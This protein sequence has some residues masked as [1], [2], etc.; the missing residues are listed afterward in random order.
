MRGVDGSEEESAD[1]K[2][3]FLPHR[4]ENETKVSTMLKCPLQLDYMLLIIRIRLPQFVKNLHFFQSG[5]IPTYE[6]SNHELIVDK[7]N[8]RPTSTLGTSQS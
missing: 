3:N 8:K 6:F 4:L 2:R 7:K 5:T 1:C